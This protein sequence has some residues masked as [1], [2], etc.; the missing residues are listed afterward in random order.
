MEELGIETIRKIIEFIEEASPIMW[1]LSQKQV[2]VN[3]L[4]N[5]TWGL[6]LIG[7]ALLMAKAA[8]WFWKESKNKR[9]DEGLWQ[10]YTV[11]VVAGIAFVGLFGLC[12]LLSGLGWAINPDYWAVKVMIGLIP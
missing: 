12:L 1:G 5:V 7:I 6:L 3:V 4:G 10:F 8:K 2:W 11:L 9:Y